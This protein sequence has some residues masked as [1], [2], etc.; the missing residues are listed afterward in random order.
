MYVFSALK[1]YANLVTSLLHLFFGIYIYIYVRS[2]NEHIWFTSYTFA[3]HT[4]YQ[5][6]YI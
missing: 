1:H 3:F 2:N 4:R 6:L 5:A